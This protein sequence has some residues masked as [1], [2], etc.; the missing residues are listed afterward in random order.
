M[1]T[2][3]PPSPQRLGLLNTR[4]TCEYLNVSLRSLERLVASGQLP[5]RRLGRQLRFNVGDLEEFF[6]RLPT[7]A[8]PWHGPRGGHDSRGRFSAAEK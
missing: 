4:Q 1:L 3:I 2:F 7:P 5:C 6:A 8:A